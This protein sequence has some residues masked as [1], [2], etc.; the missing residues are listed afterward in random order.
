MHHERWCRCKEGDFRTISCKL[1][2]ILRDNAIRSPACV[3][4]F[5]I[6]FFRPKHRSVLPVCAAILW[7]QQEGPGKWQQG[8]NCWYSKTYPHKKSRKRINRQNSWWWRTWHS[9]SSCPASWMSKLERG[10]FFPSAAKYE[11]EGR[12]APTRAGR[13]RLPR[14]QVTLGQRNPL[15]FPCQDLPSIEDQK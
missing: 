12:G 8:E 4:I 13:S 14:M 2:F 15:A 9:A 3:I 5:T 11:I 6:M 10:S 1:R 7:N